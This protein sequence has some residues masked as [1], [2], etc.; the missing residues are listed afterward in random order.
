MEN[1]RINTPAVLGGNRVIKVL[2]YNAQ[3]ERDLRDGSTS[4]IDLPK[5]NVIQLI[6]ESGDKITARPSGTEPK[7][8]FYFSVNTQLNSREEFPEKRDELEN[9]IASIQKEMNLV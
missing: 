9:K 4:R 1:L 8:K 3:E 5:S 6:T 7:I 2:D